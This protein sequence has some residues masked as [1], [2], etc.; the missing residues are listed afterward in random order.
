MRFIVVI[1]LVLSSALSVTAVYEQCGGELV[2]QSLPPVTSGGLTLLAGQM[3][4]L[5]WTYYLQ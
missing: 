3:Q 4:E 2:S 5:Y 1:G